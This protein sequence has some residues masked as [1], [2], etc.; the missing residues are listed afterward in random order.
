MPDLHAALREHFGFNSFR[1]HQEE[2]VR[3]ALDGQDTLGVLP[4]GAGKSLC[5]QLPALMLPR[6]TL[7]ISPLI[8]L[9]QDQLDGLPPAIYPRATLINSSLET[10]E[11]KRRLAGIAAGEYSLI[12][13][14]PERLRQQEFIGLL[15]RIGLSLVVVDEAHCVSVWG[16]DFRP[17][18]LFIRKALDMLDAPD[19]PTLLALT[20]TATLAMQAEIGEQLGRELETIAASVYRPNLTLEVFSCANADQKMRLL[21]RICRDTAGSGIVYANSRDRCERLAAMLQKEGVQASFYHA[22]LDRE[23]RRATQERFM[24]GR[25]RVMVA[26]VA[27]GMGVDK[28]N[29]RF[30]VHFTLPESL[31][32]YTQEAGRAGRDGKPSRCALL[33]APGDRANLT[34]WKR[35]AQVTLADVRDVYGALKERLG[36]G[37]GFVSPDEVQTAVFGA[38]ATEP[39][40][41]IKLRVAISMLE[42]CGMLQR[43]LESGHAFQIEMVPAPPSA[44]AELDAL[45]DTRRL[46]EDRR[47]ED[48]LQYAAARD[49]RHAVIAR[50]FDQELDSCGNACDCCLGTAGSSVASRDSA[51]TAAQVPDIGRVILDCCASLPFSLGRTGLARVLSAAADSPVAASRCRN[52]GA[53]AGISL[54]AIRAHL[55]TLVSEGLLHLDRESEYPLLRMTPA[56]RAAIGGASVI[57]P[58]PLRANPA[59][60]A[61]R[62]ASAGSA[63]L[64]DGAASFDPAARLQTSEDEDDRFERLR[65]WRKIEAAHKGVPPYVIFHDATLRAIAQINPEDSGR[66]SIVTGIGPRKLEAYGDAVIEALRG[67]EGPAPA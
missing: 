38:G 62:G 36:R 33:V 67:E 28:A 59:R 8:A 21:T 2:I 4:T 63:R 1:P 58:N 41:G 31:E 55:D 46:N 16:H 53:L 27:F 19:R 47:M 57:I 42:R 49:C 20:A 13:A 51:P 24:L 12:Y 25:A 11:V 30:V 65:A 60:N 45:L 18:Y 10:A 5:Y 44:R 34:R 39:K 7:V 52:H 6:P 32:S 50:H 29:V 3:A 14:A 66:L 56:G 37:A 64:A 22:G 35:D 23:T 43:R 17:D 54:N 26:T 40:Y 61:A 15:R 48:M 9:M